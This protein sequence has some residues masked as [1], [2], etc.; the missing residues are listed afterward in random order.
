METYR[1]T[2]R[3]EVYFIK[4]VKANSKDEAMEKLRSNEKTFKS[5]KQWEIN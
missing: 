2:C 3:E 1:I 4:E 5:K